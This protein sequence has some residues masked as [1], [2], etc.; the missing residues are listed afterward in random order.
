MGSVFQAIFDIN[1]TTSTDSMAIL[2]G[3]L[4]LR[5]LL[6]I[7]L[8]V[9]ISKVLLILLCAAYGQKPLMFDRKQ[10]I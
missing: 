1:Q 5:V 10:S 4:F 8:L 3:A 6:A 2:S 9:N 7:Y